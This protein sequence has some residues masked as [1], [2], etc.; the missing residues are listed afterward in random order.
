MLQTQ[1]NFNNTKHPFLYADSWEEAAEKCKN[2]LV[3]ENE[4]Q[5]MQ[6]RLL[7]W[8]NEIHNSYKKLIANEIVKSQ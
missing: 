7:E 6:N 4:L 2:L 3:N 5:E 8:W 1:Y